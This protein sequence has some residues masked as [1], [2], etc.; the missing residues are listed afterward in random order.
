M[1]VINVSHATIQA[2]GERKFLPAKH[3][4]PLNFTML[5]LANALVQLLRR[6][7][8]LQASVYL[9]RA[10]PIGTQHICDVH[11]A[12]RTTIGIQRFRPAPV[13]LRA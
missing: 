2:S 9:A 13:A 5:L 4:L 7:K 8:T 11:L 10:L 12:S 3:A 1:K 6:T